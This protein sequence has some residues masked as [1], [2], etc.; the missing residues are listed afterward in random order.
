MMHE[1]DEEEL[2][3]LW[4]FDSRLRGM[5]EKKRI[6]CRLPLNSEGYYKAWQLVI[7]GENEREDWDGYEC[8]AIGWDKYEPESEDEEAH[9]MREVLVGIFNDFWGIYGWHLCVVDND[10]DEPFADDIID[11]T[12]QIANGEQVILTIP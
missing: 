6:L 3:E 9:V 7:E 12:E 5:R 4:L 8:W 1:E 2:L 10:P 11:V